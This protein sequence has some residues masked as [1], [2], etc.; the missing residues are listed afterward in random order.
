MS[1]LIETA[2]SC[3][4]PCPSSSKVRRTAVLGVLPDHR[5]LVGR[6][7]VSPRRAR[8]CRR[9]ARDLRRFLNL[10]LR[11]RHRPLIDLPNFYFDPLA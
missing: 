9:A 5:A 8:W 2:Y 1:V 6:G 7:E 3:F 11:P 10:P 4:T